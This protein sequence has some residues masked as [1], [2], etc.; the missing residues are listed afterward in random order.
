MQ[1]VLY[2]IITISLFLWTLLVF[3]SCGLENN[4]TVNPAPTA[5][6]QPL[7]SPSATPSVTPSPTPSPK[8]SPKPKHKHKHNC[9]KG[10]R[11]CSHGDRD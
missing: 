3:V 6:V 7:P 11:T 2:Y 4:T 10:K 5:S 8:P 9:K 1:T